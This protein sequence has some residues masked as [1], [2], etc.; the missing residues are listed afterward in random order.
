VL[1]WCYE[2]EM[3]TVNL[4]HASTLYGQYNKRVKKNI[5]EKVYPNEK[6]S[7]GL[8]KNSSNNFILAKSYRVIIKCEA[9]SIATEFSASER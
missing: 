6:N 7:L 5:F 3:G 9:Q 1:P 2:A 4:L 8:R